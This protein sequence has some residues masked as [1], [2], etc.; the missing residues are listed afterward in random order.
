MERFNLGTL[1][2][3]KVMKQYQT[4]ISKRFGA[5]ENIILV[6]FTIFRSKEAGYNTV[7]TGSTPKQYR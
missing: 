4:K 1:S 7:I 2:E 6:R 5:L 3:L